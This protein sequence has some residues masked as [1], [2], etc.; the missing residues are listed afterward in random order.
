MNYYEYLKMY[1]PIEGENAEQNR[2][3]T[4][5]RLQSFPRPGGLGSKFKNHYEKMLKAL[6][7]PKG[8][9][10]ELDFPIEV[11]DKVLNGQPLWEETKKK[12]DDDDD[13]D[14]EVRPDENADQNKLT[15]EQ[16]NL[17][18]MY[19]EGRYHLIPS[20]FRTISSLKKQKREFAV[21]FRTFG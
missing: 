5:D 13:D 11:V 14:A 15:D 18:T 17:L 3:I 9:K 20:F 6:A 12:S 4:S 1:W 2:A 21:T 7:L 10:E 8:A 16:K 19:A